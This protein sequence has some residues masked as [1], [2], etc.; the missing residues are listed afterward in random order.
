MNTNP[1]RFNTLS[2]ES[3]DSPENKR[4]SVKA[5]A[6]LFPLAALIAAVVLWGG[7][8][9]GMRMVLRELH[10]LSVMWCRMIIA[11]IVMVPMAKYLVPVSFR[12]EDLKLLVPMVLLQPCSYFLLESN[13]LLFTTSSQAGVI[14]ASVPMLVTV[15]AV[16]F[17]RET[18]AWQVLA[19]LLISVAGVA[20]LTLM[21]EPVGQGS[22]P[23]VGNILE[24]FA[25]AC[26]AGNM[27][28]VKR[29]SNRFNPWSLT[30][31][32][33]LAGSIFFL[34]GGVLLFRVPG[35]VWTRGL[36][37][38]LIFLGVGV[39]LGAFGLYNFG[40]SRIS[41]S[42]ASAFING[43]PVVAVVLGW[44]LLGE[45]LNAWQF[46][47]G[48]AVMAGVAVTQKAWKASPNTCR[49]TRHYRQA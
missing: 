15:G 39:T 29:L 48:G 40:I 27:L 8:F 6:T 2:L 38:S 7:S 5:Q 30:A 19:G 45:A 23:H 18:V 16:V 3:S 36:V 41:A 13:A 44:A 9:V 22:N 33:V 49:K 35:V 25:M 42:R 28:L 14:S 43:V 31:M 32:Q 34:P 17:F 37:A 26:A 20:G 4:I 21:A 1:C 11:L 24:F 10:P 46:V 12:K 47:A